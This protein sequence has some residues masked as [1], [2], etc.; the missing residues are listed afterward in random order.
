MH[1]LAWFF[2]ACFFSN[3]FAN[4]VDVF[5]AEDKISAAIVKEYG[6]EVSSFEAELFAKRLSGL[7]AKESDAYQH[8]QIQLEAQVAKKFNFA[9]VKFDTVYYPDKSLYTT[10]NVLN[11]VP[12]ISNYAAY[13]LKK[14]Y[15]IVDR[16]YLFSKKAASIYAEHPE[17]GEHMSCKDFH[18]IVSEN[19]KIQKELDYLRTSVPHQTE[20]I[21]E[22]M[23]TDK[24]LARRR[25]AIFLL[26]YYPSI[27]GVHARLDK[28]LKA[29]DRFILHDTLRVYG[30]LLVKYPKLKLDLSRPIVLLHHYDEAIRNKALLLINAAA[31]Q[32]QYKRFI[33]KQGAYELL[34]L[35]KLKQPNNHDIAYQILLKTTKQKYGDRDYAAWESY[36]RKIM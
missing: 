23:F 12:Q 11:Q 30:E 8:R 32:K 29:D 6:A 21:D 24:N 15:D 16:M 22:V 19:S 2:S 20:F 4:N 9:A 35:L 3:V 5:G 27:E 14:P 36:L 1:R 33:I 13:P 7:S 28:L 25:A 34:S 26:A 18:C 10:I 17:I 31:E